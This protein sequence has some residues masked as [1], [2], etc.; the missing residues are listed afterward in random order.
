MYNVGEVCL[1]HMTDAFND[2]RPSAP[3][4]E[5]F[6]EGT[7]TTEYPT[8]KYIYNKSYFLLSKIQQERNKR[9]IYRRPNRLQALMLM[10]VLKQ[11]KKYLKFLIE[12]KILENYSISQKLYYYY[13]FK[14]KVKFI[15]A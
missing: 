8:K 9:L 4:T 3:T 7:Q 14:F 6:L 2:G 5:D 15:A 13:Y 10:V 11:T 1:I 12:R